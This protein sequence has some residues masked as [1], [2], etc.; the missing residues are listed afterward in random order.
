[1]N[2]FEQRRREAHQLA[3]IIDESLPEN[4]DVDSLAI[5]TLAI[6]IGCYK[7]CDLDLATLLSDAARAWEIK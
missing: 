6:A 2:T 1:M 5:A 7:E 4:Y 3:H